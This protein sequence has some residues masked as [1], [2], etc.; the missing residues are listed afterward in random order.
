MSVARRTAGYWA[1]S[2]EG[3]P[4]DRSPCFILPHGVAML[5]L[6]NA[7]ADSLQAYPVVIG[8]DG[9]DGLDD[10]LSAGTGP[11]CFPLSANF[12]APQH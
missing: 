4:N 3:R 12:D 1:T 7:L 5:Q 11:P 10:D 9:Q 6:I 2:R 8:H